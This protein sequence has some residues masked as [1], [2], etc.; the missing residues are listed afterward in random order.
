MDD[1]FWQQQAMLE[2]EQ[3]LEEALLRA[4][5]HEATND[6][7]QIIYSEC[8]LTWRQENGTDRKRL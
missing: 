5:R 4:R 8:G 7:W 3:M 6:D 1:Q 2:R